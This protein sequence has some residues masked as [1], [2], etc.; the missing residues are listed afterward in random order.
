MQCY[1]ALHE[2][3]VKSEIKHANMWNLQNIVWKCPIDHHSCI[4]DCDTVVDMENRC[5]ANK[6]FTVMVMFIYSGSLFKFNAN[7]LFSLFALSFPLSMIA[8]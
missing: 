4:T 5:D 7:I 6:L 2:R 8:F 1:Y 3:F